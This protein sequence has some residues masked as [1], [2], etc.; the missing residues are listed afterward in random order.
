MKSKIQINFNCKK[1]VILI[2][3]FFYNKDK[4][5]LFF[6]GNRKAILLIIFNF[7]KKFKMKKLIVFSTVLLGGFMIAQKKITTIY[8]TLELQNMHSSLPANEQQQFYVQYLKANL[9][10]NIR[11]RFNSKQYSDN[12]LKKLT[13]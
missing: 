2:I 4:I 7:T 3:N 1:K 9:F 13:D 12:L 6:T 11:T 5:F 10:E 8:S